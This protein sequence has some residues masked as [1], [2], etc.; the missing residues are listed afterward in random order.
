M[1]D[2]LN[3]DFIEGLDIN[4]FFTKRIYSLPTLVLMVRLKGGLNQQMVFSS[5]FCPD[6][7]FDVLLYHATLVYVYIQL[8]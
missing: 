2:V 3:M 4:H 8:H 1:V 6:W 7:Y 5:F